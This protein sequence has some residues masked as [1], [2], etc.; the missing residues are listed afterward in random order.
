MHSNGLI[1]PWS[2]SHHFMEPAPHRW[3]VILLLSVCRAE[4]ALSPSGRAFLQH[5]ILWLTCLFPKFHPR[6]LWFSFLLLILWASPR[7]FRPPSVRP[8]DHLHQDGSAWAGGM[9]VK[10]PDWQASSQNVYT[11]ACGHGIQEASS[12]ISSLND[13]L[14]HCSVAN[15]SCVID[16]CPSERSVSVDSLSPPC[17]PVR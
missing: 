10:K 2:G 13:R 9:L 1:L 8:S 6:V 16:R 4:A 5:L 15:I 11:G 7:L 12:L 14:A 3:P 17:T